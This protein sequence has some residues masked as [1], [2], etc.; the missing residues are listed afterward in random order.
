MAQEDAK[1]ENYDESEKW[2]VAGNNASFHANVVKITKGC[3]SA[4]GT[5]LISSGKHQWTVKVT[6]SSPTCQWIGVSTDFTV[7]NDHFAVKPNSMLWCNNCQVIQGNIGSGHN[8]CLASINPK[9]KWTSGDC[10]TI[11]LDLDTN[12]IE[13]YRNTNEKP[14]VIYSNVPKGEYKLAV[15]GYQTP[16][17]TFEIVSSKG[18]GLPILSVNKEILPAI[19]RSTNALNNFEQ[20]IKQM[21]TNSLLISKKN[22]KQFNNEYQLMLKEFSDYADLVKKVD[23]LITNELNPTTNYKTWNLKQVIRWIC[24]LENGTFSKYQNSLGTAMGEQEFKGKDLQYVEK[25]D[26]LSFG[27]KN[28]GDRAA[29]YREIQKLINSAENEGNKTAHM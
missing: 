24:S 2:T 14:H 11:K 22:I 18:D 1:Y 10:I 28:F 8:S 9:E 7:T 23:I 4:Y 15:Y 21:E 16:N 13:F 25:N 6:F 26:L 12:T 20:R 29:L 17:D 5:K 19:Q 27:V 3:G